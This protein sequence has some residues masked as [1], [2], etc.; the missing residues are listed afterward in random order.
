MLYNIKLIRQDDEYVD[1]EI[2]ILNYISCV[3]IIT[4]EFN[5]FEHEFYNYILI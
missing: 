2:I 3:T 4:C 1:K 5:Q